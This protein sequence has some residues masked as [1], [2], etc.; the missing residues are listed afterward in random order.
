MSYGKLYVQPASS[1]DKPKVIDLKLTS[2]PLLFGWNEGCGIR[3]LRKQV[4]GEHAQIM[5][6]KSG[7]VWLVH[8]DEVYHTLVNGELVKDRRELKD[9]DIISIAGRDFIYEEVKGD[10]PKEVRCPSEL[11]HHHH[12]HGR[13]GMYVAPLEHWTSSHKDDSSATSS[14]HMDHKL[15]KIHSPGLP[16]TNTSQNSITNLRREKDTGPRCVEVRLQV[17]KQ[18]DFGYA[19]WVCGSTDF[20]GN[21]NNERAIR[22]QWAEGNIWSV[23]LENKGET[24]SKQFE[25]KYMIRPDSDTTAGTWEQGE[26][27]QLTIETGKWTNDQTPFFILQ[28]K[29]DWEDKSKREIVQEAFSQER[30]GETIQEYT[31]NHES[32]STV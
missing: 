10:L 12:P 3:I 2:E 13:T 4:A 18:V 17:H 27:R 1:E 30:I 11:H 6:E 26:N 7:T 21:W 19:I 8:L 16:T 9:Q 15:E 14:D 29:D 32:I 24:F 31:M 28:A 5:R 25:Y 22:M 23:T 20:L